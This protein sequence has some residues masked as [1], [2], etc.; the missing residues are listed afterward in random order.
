MPA[1]HGELIFAPE[2]QAQ[3]VEFFAT[4]LAREHATVVAAY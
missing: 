3:Y 2:A 4:G 1:T